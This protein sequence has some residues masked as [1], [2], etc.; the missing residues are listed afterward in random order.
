MAEPAKRCLVKAI[1]R[2]MRNPCR[3]PSEDPSRVKNQ[4]Q[5]RSKS[6]SVPWQMLQFYGIHSV[7]PNS[8]SQAA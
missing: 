7:N 1:A 4:Q 8:T 6:S 2:L 5:G 3:C